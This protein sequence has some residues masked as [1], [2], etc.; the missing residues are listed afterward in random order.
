LLRLARQCQVGECWDNDT[1]R[2][3]WEMH[4][5]ELTGPLMLS[6]PTSDV[7]DRAVAAF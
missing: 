2:R 7:V 6:E 4:L 1:A 5:V 3:W